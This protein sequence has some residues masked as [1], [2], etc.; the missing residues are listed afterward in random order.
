MN[1]SASLYASA[2]LAETQGRPD[3]ARQYRDWAK[4]ARELGQDFGNA[5]YQHFAREAAEYVTRRTAA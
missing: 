4:S 3:L 1:A 5:L 2:D